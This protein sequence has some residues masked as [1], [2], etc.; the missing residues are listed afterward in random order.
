MIRV[1]NIGTG[2]AMPHAQAI[3]SL[4]RPLKA[5]IG[6]VSTSG[7]LTRFAL[8]YASMCSYTAHNLVQPH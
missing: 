3:C 7:I 1:T 4:I 6:I 5:N 2:P 8:R